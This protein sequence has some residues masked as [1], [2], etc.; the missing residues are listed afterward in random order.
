MNLPVAYCGIFK[1]SRNESFFGKDN[2]ERLN[3]D[4]GK[5]RDD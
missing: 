1:T 5:V 4:G 3:M 2:P